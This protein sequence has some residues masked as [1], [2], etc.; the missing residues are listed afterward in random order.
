MT[1]SAPISIASITGK[2]RTTPPSIN[3]FPSS[4]IGSKMDGKDIL[5]RIAFAKEP[6]F[7]TTASPVSASVATQRKGIL[8]WSK[9]CTP[10]AG[11]VN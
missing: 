8:N 6:L 2:F 9:S 5:A 3:N 4:S 7:K 1:M 11:N 10:C